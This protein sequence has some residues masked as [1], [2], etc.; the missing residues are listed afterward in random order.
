MLSDKELQ[1]YINT[2]IKLFYKY[3]ARNYNYTYFIYEENLKRAYLI[4]QIVN[5][6]SSNGYVNNESAE[7][8]TVKKLYNVIETI[9]KYD[10]FATVRQYDFW[11]DGTYYHTTSMSFKKFCEKHL[12][13]PLK[14]RKIL[15]EKDKNIHHPLFMIH[16]FFIKKNKPFILYAPYIKTTK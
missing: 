9:S 7:F 14:K 2:N 4:N 12:E 5:N 16:S 1:K 10:I 15:V 8:N 11:L 3:L 6:G 13:F